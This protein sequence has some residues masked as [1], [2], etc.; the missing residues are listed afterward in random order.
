MAKSIEIPIRVWY[1]DE[2]AVIRMA[3]DAS[4]GFIST[5]NDDPDSARGNPNLFGKLAKLLRDAGRPAPVKLNH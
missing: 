4:I 1:D 2:Q 3:S 5:V